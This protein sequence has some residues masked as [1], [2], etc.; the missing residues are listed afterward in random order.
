M[1]NDLPSSATS[2]GSSED[3]DSG[4]LLFE[5]VPV[6]VFRYDRDLVIRDCNEALCAILHASAE[7]LC[8]LSM[9]ALRDQRPV[10]A[11]RAALEGRVGRYEG[12][13]QST[14][15]GVS[16]WSEVR[17]SPFHDA[18]GAIVGG[19]AIVRDL[20]ETVRAERAH[21]AL[22]LI[23][24]AAHRAPD[25]SAVAATIASALATMQ[26]DLEIT[27]RP[28]WDLAG[29]AG[30]LADRL[31]DQVVLS[32][33]ASSLDSEGLRAAAQ[34]F[35]AG[36]S[37]PGGAI[38]GLLEEHFAVCRWSG[39]PLLEGD[40]VTGG[41]A[42]GLRG[43][44]FLDDRATLDLLAGQVAIVVDRK[45]QSERVELLARRDDLTGLPNRRAL[46][47]V[48]EAALANRRG[49]AL[50]FADL[51]RFK[52]INDMLGHDSGDELLR[53][54]GVVFRDLSEPEGRMCSRLGGDEF[55]IWAPECEA[56]CAEGIAQG[57]R[58][59]L[60]RTFSVRGHRVRIAASVGV[61]L[62]PAH[63]QTLEQLLRGAD[64]ALYQAKESGGFAQ[65]FDPTN[66]G[67]GAPRL[68]FETLLR[69]AIGADALRLVFQP[70]M[71]LATGQVAGYEAL[72]RWPL[73]GRALEAGE[74]VPMAEES[75]L[76]RRL[77][78]WVLRQALDCLE[79][80]EHERPFLA[81]NVSARSLQDHQWVE[82]V[83]ENCRERR[84]EP[85]RLV[86]EITESAAIRR[87][88]EAAASL[89]ALRAGGIR[90]AIDDFGSGFA[91]LTSLRS[92]PCD[93]LKIDRSLV[94]EIGAGAEPLLTASIALGHGL[95]LAVVAEGIET[96]AQ[97]A[98][99]REAGCGLGQGWLWGRPSRWHERPQSGLVLN[100]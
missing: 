49:G 61:A 54:V 97:C 32:G 6:G 31:L 22:W 41:V 66:S 70:I 3:V 100:R 92:L 52:R 53:Q 85:G 99:L 73:G 51:D 5:Q 67:V 45:R 50:L 13:Y 62:A 9:L 17:A 78:E 43:P 28:S 27:V 80:S 16:I 26:V 24:E 7:K 94:S 69:E 36:P 86:L 38:Q 12:P 20:T 40:R 21:R 58:D 98:W 74:F 10:A 15:A 44:G 64:I 96:E 60:D 11:C 88:E 91:S 47:E 87:P 63:G 77:D 35:G 59:A 30:S 1:H 56:G 89:R 75:D 48:V 39:I 19:I 65:V 34:M 4:R 84:L 42:I 25:T 46:R 81:V 23:S 37:E 90:V 14:L 33:R 79:A 95:G 8:G 29:A 68:E 83:L 55:A 93:I 2:V 76:V 18:S 72:V 71:E 57:L 82:R